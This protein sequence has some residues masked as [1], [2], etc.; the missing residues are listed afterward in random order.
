MKDIK[1][2][3]KWLGLVNFSFSRTA[4]ESWN[5][6]SPKQLIAIAK[7]YMGEEQDNTFVANMLNIPKY[8]TRRLDP[9][10]VFKIIEAFD[11]ISDFK[12]RDS[13][14]F[15][16]LNCGQAPKHRLSDLSFGRFVFIDTYF[17]DYAM[18]ES[19]DSLNKFIACL[20]WPAKTQFSENLIPQ[21][22]AKVAK[23]D[24]TFK[25]AIAINYRLVKDWLGAAYPLV[26]VSGNEKANSPERKKDSPLLKVFDAIVGDDIVNSDKYARMPLH[27]VLRYITK[28]IKENA[29]RS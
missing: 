6:V 17:Y 10:Y 28:K 21:R 29:K 25:Q 1:I 16:R 7:S 11:F 27:E 15:K 5:E 19:D 3:Y 9:F 22:A 2:T 23:M 4:P 14:V 12:P 24:K 8:I 26:F 13:L 18:D 20:Y